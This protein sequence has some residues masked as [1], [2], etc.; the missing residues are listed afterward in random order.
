MRSRWSASSALILIALVAAGGLW[1]CGGSRDSLT[2]PVAV[3]DVGD[4]AGAVTSSGAGKV[5]ICHKRQDLQVAASALAGH[6]R[7]GD[8]VGSCA[9]VCPCF[10]STGIGEVAALCGVTP[11]ASCPVQYSINLF[12]APGGSGGSVS[13]LGLFQARLGTNTCSTTTQDPLTGEPVTATMAVTPVQYEACKQAII[14]N[15]YYP[16][17]CPR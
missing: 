12:C 1:S 9:A 13:N 17:S 4:E 15:V 2:A 8:R 3:L 6:L 7:H 5:T 14:G 16:A 11:I 10:T